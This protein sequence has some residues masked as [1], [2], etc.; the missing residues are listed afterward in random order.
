[1]ITTFAEACGKYENPKNRE[2]RMGMNYETY[3]T[4]NLFEYFIAQKLP[5]LWLIAS[6][7]FCKAQSKI[8]TWMPIK[9]ALHTDCYKYRLQAA[10]RNMIYIRFRISNLTINMNDFEPL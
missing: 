5:I 8:S 10:T 2:G 4:S 1:M 6:V 3:K 9:H 7:I